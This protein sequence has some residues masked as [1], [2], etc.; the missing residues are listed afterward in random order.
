M[1]PVRR[2][3]RHLRGNLVAYLALMVALGG[4]SYAGIALDARSVG[5]KELKRGAVTRAKIKAN[6]VSPGKLSNAAKQALTGPQGAPGAPGAPGQ[7][8]DTGATGPTFTAFGRNPVN[9]ALP[10]DGIVVD[11][12]GSNGSAA[13][14]GSGALTLPEQSRVYVSGSA[15]MTNTDPD[16]PI[17]GRC[18]AL[19]SQPASNALTDD[20]GSGFFTDFHEAS[21]EQT[22]AANQSHQAMPVTGTVLVPAGTYNVGIH[23]TQ[24]GGPAGSLNRFNAALNVFAVPASS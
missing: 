23:C 11:L 10:G 22:G 5:T 2:A 19:I 17:R 21:T 4:T 20:A 9:G 13:T 1:V 8:G 15:T 18:E 6:A 3:L 7:K 16:D 24:V 14:T 12:I